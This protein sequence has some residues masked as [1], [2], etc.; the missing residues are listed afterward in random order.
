MRSRH[1]VIV[2][3]VILTA[4]LTTFLAGG[5]GRADPGNVEQRIAAFWARVN[6]MQPGDFLSTGDLGQWALNV[7]DRD[8]R[9]RLTVADF[10]AATAQMQAAIDR[11]GPAAAPASPAPTPAP[12][13]SMTYTDG[14]KVALLEWGEQAPTR[15]VTPKT[16]MRFVFVRLRFD[17]GSAAAVSVSTYFG[18]FTL[19]D[20]NGVRRVPSYHDGRT[21]QLL[22]GD[23]APG[24]FLSGTLV[25]EA[26]IGDVGLRLIYEKYRYEQATLVLR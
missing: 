1:R 9:S 16:G 15:Y 24:A 8:A 5:V 26:P 23:V 20:S 17:N 13:T 6:A 3:A 21:D 11:A 12:R 25:F 2:V 4:I 10:R 22:S 7:I 19:Q 14:W 18:E